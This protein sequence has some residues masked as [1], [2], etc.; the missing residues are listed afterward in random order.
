MVTSGKF[1]MTPMEGRLRCAGIVEFGGMSEKRSR[2]PFELL[3]RQTLALFPELEY[4]R[5]EEWMGFRPSTTDSLPLIG[6]SER[7][8]N[9]WTGFG[10]QHIGLTAGPKTGRWLAQMIDGQKPNVD[11]G[12]FSPLRFKP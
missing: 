9:V 1:V 4:E 11:L 12:A 8:S 2:G 10:H 5:I 6:A 3:K 7:H